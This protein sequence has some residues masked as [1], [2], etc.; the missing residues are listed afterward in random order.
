MHIAASERT[1][2]RPLRGRVGWVQ[3]EQVNLGSKRRPLHDE[4]S[5]CHPAHTFGRGMGRERNRPRRAAAA[6]RIVP[7]SSELKRGDAAAAVESLAV[8]TFF[9]FRHLSGENGFRFSNNKSALQH[10]CL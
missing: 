6:L 1:R 8:D 10:F 9:C 4:K 7:S 2:V 3:R 5:M